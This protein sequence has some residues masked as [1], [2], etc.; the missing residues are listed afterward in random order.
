MCP[1]LSKGD[2]EQEG[3]DA[4]SEA[5]DDGRDSGRGSGGRSAGRGWARSASRFTDTEAAELR[6]KL[7]REEGL[8]AQAR[9]LP[10]RNGSWVLVPVRPVSTGGRDETCP[11]CTGGAGG[12]G[13]SG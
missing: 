8:A 4:D 10:G 6:S 9:T 12:G 3:A 1:I 5:S 2:E 13:Q 11:V 7:V